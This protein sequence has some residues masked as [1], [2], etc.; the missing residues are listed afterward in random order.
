MIITMWTVFIALL[1]GRHILSERLFAFLAHKNHLR[2]LLQGVCLRFTVAFGA[3]VPLF[4][5][6]STDGDLSV[7]DVFTVCSEAIRSLVH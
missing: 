3:I 7:Q 2:C 6:W 4:A 5:A 1:V